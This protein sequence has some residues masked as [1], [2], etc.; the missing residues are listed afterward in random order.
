MELQREMKSKIFSYLEDKGEGVV[1]AHKKI[2]EANSVLNWYK[3]D[4]KQKI[5]PTQLSDI[6][7]RILEEEM[8]LIWETKDGEDVPMLTKP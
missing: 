4:G 3:E 1:K 6:I 7:G 2:F 5:T 8:K